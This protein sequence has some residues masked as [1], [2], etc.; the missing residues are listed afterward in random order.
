MFDRHYI[1]Y[2]GHGIFFIECAGCVSTSVLDPQKVSSREHFHSSTEYS[3]ARLLTSAAVHTRFTTFKLTRTK[4]ESRPVT[5]RWLSTKALSW[6]NQRNLCS[7]VSTRICTSRK[8][9]GDPHSEMIDSFRHLLP[10]F[11]A[12]F[13]THSK[14]QSPP[15]SPGQPP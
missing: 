10:R 2:C 5:D 4:L 13:D 7:P 9:H 15:E 1:F 11:S 8:T 3:P 12:K 6:L 14:S